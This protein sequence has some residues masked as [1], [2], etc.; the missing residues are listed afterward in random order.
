MDMWR[1][2]VPGTVNTGKKT[3]ESGY[4]EILR[5]NERSQEEKGQEQSLEIEGL[6]V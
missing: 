1:D 4:R 5:I 3:T 2:A 6:T